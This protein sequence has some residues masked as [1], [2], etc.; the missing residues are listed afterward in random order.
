M[1]DCS[2]ECSDVSHIS[3]LDDQC[4]S[5]NFDLSNCSP[6]DTDNFNIVHYNIN[7]ILAPGKIDEL[8][9]YCRLI[10]IGVLIMTES[11]LDD[12]IL[13]NLFIIPGYHEPISHDRQINGRYGGGV[14]IY[15][16]NNLVFQ[17]K[18]TFNQTSMSISGPMSGLMIQYLP[19][20]RFIDH[21]MKQ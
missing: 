9:D 19:L 16:A 12:T 2:S 15:V 4:K 13:I 11:K 10:N 3:E 18:P 21:Q 5:L 1:S 7:S 8:S 6:I 20:M 17:H 14:L